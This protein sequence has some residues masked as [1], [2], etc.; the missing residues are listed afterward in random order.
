MQTGQLMPDMTHHGPSSR[1][2]DQL[3]RAEHDFVAHS[4]P[5]IARMLRRK[6]TKIE[7]KPE[8]REEVGPLYP[9]LPTHILGI[10]PA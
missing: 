8:D 3:M 10:G 9:I 6:L 2:S 7:L 4:G 1:C 5:R